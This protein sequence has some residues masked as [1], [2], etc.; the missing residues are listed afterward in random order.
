[1][2]FP[3]AGPLPHVDP[4]VDRPGL[5]EIGQLDALPCPQR[6]LKLS[7][8]AGPGPGR[9]LGQRIGLLQDPRRAV[10]GPA[11]GTDHD[12]P[13]GRK[14]VGQ[15]GQPLVD[16]RNRLL[17]PFEGG[18]LSEALQD[19][20]VMPA[21]LVQGEVGPP[22][23]VLRDDQLAA[24]IDL[25]PSD[26]TGGELRGGG[27][28]AKRFDVVTE[29][30]E[31]DGAAR[32]RGEEV[33]DAPPDGELSAVLDHVDPRVAQGHQA[34]GQ[35][36]GG[37][38]RCCLQDEGFVVSERRDQTLDGGEDGGHHDHGSGPTPKKMGRPG[39]RAGDMGSRADPFV[40]EGLPGGEA[41]HAIRAEERRC[42]GGQH[43][44]RVRVVPDRQDRGL[45]RR[46]QGGRH[47]GMAGRGCVGRPNRARR[48]QEPLERP[49]ADRLLQNFLQF[50]STHSRLGSQTAR[51]GPVH[52]TRP[53][54]SPS[55]FTRGAVGPVT[56][57]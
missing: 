37:K 46:R 19:P 47:E 2:N 14:E 51:R 43:V 10:G 45:D 50:L 40:R 34:F 44:R 6:S 27:E 33:D 30:I 48:G 26:L 4:E 8:G 21:V 36:V 53:L 56:R 11:S 5:G 12:P 22:P 17:H 23:H 52:R 7:D 9:G 31:P 3:L 41:H 15:H 49:R 39:P 24:R 16:E 38:R 54:T 18:A 57:F 29:V 35:G 1:M 32:R 25:D 13:A 20:G 42:P 55:L 28:L